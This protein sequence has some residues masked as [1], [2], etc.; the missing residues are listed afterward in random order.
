M[1]YL[2]FSSHIGTI[3]QFQVSASLL[4]QNIGMH[5]EMQLYYPPY[6]TQTENV[7]VSGN[8]Q[9]VRS[10]TEVPKQKR[11][12]TLLSVLCFISAMGVPASHLM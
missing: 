9:G 11:V 2:S 1:E 6:C 8:W 10:T 7:A 4:F 5:I 12:A 3:I